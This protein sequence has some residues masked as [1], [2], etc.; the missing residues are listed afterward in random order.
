MPPGPLS[1]GKTNMDEFAMGSSTETSYYKK[2]K[3][4][5]NLNCVPG[6]FLGR[7]RRLRFRRPG[8]CLAGFGYGRFHPPARGPLRHCGAETH[9]WAGFPLWFDRFRLLPGPGRPHDKD[10]EDCALMMERH[11]GP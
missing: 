6:R 4:P 1:V 2:T 8:L 11:R 5:W 7:F 9:L 3:N 10:V